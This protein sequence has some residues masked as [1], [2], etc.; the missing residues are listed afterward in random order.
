MLSDQKYII[1]A[2]A[3]PKLITSVKESNSLPTLDVPF[4]NLAIRP[5]KPSMIAAA[6]IAIIAISNLLSNANLIELKP[7][8]TPTNVKIFGKITLALFSVTS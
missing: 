7:M 3:T 8:H 5:S 4:N 2:G 6:I 1:K